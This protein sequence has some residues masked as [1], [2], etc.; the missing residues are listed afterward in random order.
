MK[1]LHYL[2]ERLFG[3][4]LVVAVTMLAACGGGSD[5]T[6]NPPPPP[7]ATAMGV[8]IDSP[9]QGLAYQSGAVSGSTDATGT[10]D[11]TV[12]E[13]LSFS[14]GGVALGTLTT[15]A[16]IVTPYD[17]GAAAENIAR[18][19]QSL[20]ADGNHANGIDLVAAA[21][22]LADTVADA[23]IFM[24]DATTFEMDIAPILEAAM[25]PGAELVNAATAMANLV[26]A[27]DSTFE[28]EELAGN[29]FVIEI[30]EADD[31]GIISFSALENPE[32]TGSS[33]ELFMKADTI[34]D[35][36][37]GTT[38]VLTWSVDDNGVL[39]VEDPDEL[40]AITITKAGGS[41]NMI[42][43]VL[44]GGT[45]ELAG[46]F[47]VPANGTV[48]DLAGESGRSY[49]VIDDAGESTLTFF[50]SGRSTRVV[51]DIVIAED[52]VLD[53]SGTLITSFGD[54]SSIRLSVLI[55]GSFAVGGEA[56]TISGTNASGDPN[57]LLLQLGELS[58]SVVSPIVPPGSE[59]AVIYSFATSTSG[60]SADETLNAIFTGTSVSGSFKYANW[61]PA[62]LVTQGAS[63]PGSALY[64]GSVLDIAGTANGS[65]FADSSGN[66]VVG[67]ERFV[68]TGQTDFLHFAA[69]LIETP[70][71]V[72]G[73]ELSAI[74]WFWIEGDTTEEDFLNSDLL[75]QSLPG[76]TGRLSLDFT[77]PDNQDVTVSVFFEGLVVTPEL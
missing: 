6:T 35:G 10:F 11:Y 75:P 42:T 61:I 7:P 16:P 38:T 66:T 12:G 47:L 45:E 1:H 73:Y 37:D 17:F 71:T 59:T 36:G 48:E 9:V 26:A 67:N 44:T 33:V 14:V 18:F 13:T 57:D 25:G 28:K 65:V 43:I 77:L 39:T 60:S 70:F 8:F 22:A 3:T 53:E 64:V 20:D 58:F 46:R 69:P 5:S 50:P 19:L 4:I 21:T 74:R 41:M 40:G 55:N 24:S 2:R 72:N 49:V 15:G 68:P 30:P 56:V 29:I 51:N 62:L 27:T 52:W 54:N 76:L 32:D 63:A 34:E 31:V 23:S